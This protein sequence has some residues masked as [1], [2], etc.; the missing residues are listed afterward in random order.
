MRPT[1]LVAAV[2]LGVALA[3]RCEVST[4]VVHCEA[5]C[6]GVNATSYST[7]ASGTEALLPPSN[8]VELLAELERDSGASRSKSSGGQPLMMLQ[9][10]ESWFW[11][12]RQK[13]VYAPQHEMLSP[14][15]LIELIGPLDK[16]EWRNIRGSSLGCVDGRH[17]TSGLYAYGGDFGELLLALTVYEHMV[18]RKLTQVDRHH[19]LQSPPH[20]PSRAPTAVP[21]GS[22][23]RS[24]CC[25]VS[26][27]PPT[28][29]YTAG[30]SVRRP[31]RPPT[32]TSG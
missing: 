18:Q 6:D 17:S 11:G 10:Q 8:A 30:R 20:L 25:E 26:A 1:S 27:H 22:R 31:R 24:I 16:L 19:H 29:T 4:I 12:S 21:G 2:A 14:D 23:R 15:Q 3:E 28:T 7:T 13:E 9:M 5:R 32:S